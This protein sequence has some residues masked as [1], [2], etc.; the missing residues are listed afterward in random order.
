MDGKLNGQ[1]VAFDIEKVNDSSK[2]SREICAFW[3]AEQPNKDELIRSE[4]FED[5]SGNLV[6]QLSLISSGRYIA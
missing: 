5:P 6:E 4:V 2:Y 1:I 3:A